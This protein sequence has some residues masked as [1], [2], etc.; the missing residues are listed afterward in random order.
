MNGSL[1]ALSRGNNSTAG[2]GCNASSPYPAGGLN[3]G[4]RYSREFTASLSG[5]ITIQAPGDLEDN[6]TSTKK[7]LVC[8]PEL[9]K[10]IA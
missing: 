10:E 3:V 5:R 8:A 1:P 4:K 7:L 2:P 6:H 9:W